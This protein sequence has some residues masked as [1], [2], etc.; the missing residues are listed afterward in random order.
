MNIAIQL[1]LAGGLFALFSF[2][3]FFVDFVLQT[4]FEAMN[5]H[6]NPKI[7]AHHCLIYAI[8][9]IPLMI[10]LNF[11]LW[12]FIVGFVVLF[13]S[14][15]YLDTY[16]AVF[17]WAKYIRQPPEMTDPHKESYLREDGEWAIKVLPPDPVKGFVQFVSTPLGKILMIAI[18]QISH[19]SFLWILVWLGLN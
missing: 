15:F 17:L 5:K 3:H 8:G 14:H 1:A 11:K 19:L 6:N 10:V 2:V 7:R 12:E 9:F 4:H 16:H 13:A 18:D